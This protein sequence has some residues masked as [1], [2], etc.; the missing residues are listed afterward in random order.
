MKFG[1]HLRRVS[2]NARHCVPSPEKLRENADADTSADTN[3][4]YFHLG[5]LMSNGSLRFLG[6]V[7]RPMSGSEFIED[8]SL[9][10]P[11]LP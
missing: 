10:R 11:N 4:C 6:S 2:G 3:Q 5:L 8:P 9:R 7:E 1:C